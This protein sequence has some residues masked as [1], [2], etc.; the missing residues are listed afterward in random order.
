MGYGRCARLGFGHPGGEEGAWVRVGVS[1]CTRG[2]WRL[3]CV[4]VLLI[5]MDLGGRGG[6]AGGVCACVA[7]TQGRVGRWVTVGSLG[8]SW[9]WMR[10]GDGWH[11]VHA[12]VPLRT[13]GLAAAECVGVQMCVNVC[14]NV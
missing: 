8:R 1:P 10:G 4:E 6:V 7:H 2:A 14:V 13:E 9:C 5:H 12:C 3:L 11:R